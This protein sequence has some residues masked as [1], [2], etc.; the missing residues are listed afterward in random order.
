MPLESK[1][2]I[3]RSPSFIRTAPL[4]NR[5]S[6]FF[7]QNIEDPF[8][9]A[10]LLKDL[11]PTPKNNTSMPVIEEDYQIKEDISE[12]KDD[13]IEV[14]K[15]KKDKKV[16]IYPE[17]NQVLSDIDQVL[18]EINEVLPDITD[19]LIEKSEDI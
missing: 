16:K 4:E 10:T 18:P 7:K 17:V 9:S 11:K 8:R 6:M 5:S 15:I 2:S 3:L 1:K 14:P 12:I 19:D 13:S